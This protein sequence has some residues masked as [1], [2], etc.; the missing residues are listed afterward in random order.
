MIPP[1]VIDELQGSYWV[2]SW[3]FA[4]LVLVV[5]VLLIATF[6]VWLRRRRHLEAHRRR[7]ALVSVGATVLIVIAAGVFANSYSGYI[8]NAPAAI[9][10]VKGLVGSHKVSGATEA[11]GGL[12]VITMP[13]DAAGTVPATQAWVYTP[14]GYDPQ[15]SVHY[16]VLYLFH[17]TPGRSS[18]WFV[19]GNADNAMN[20]LLAHGLVEP[21]I[22]VS[23]DVNGGGKRA[24]TE[25]LDWDD[26]PKVETWMLT[27]VVPFIDASY[28]TIPDRSG[29]AI[30]G[31]SSGGFCALNLALRNLGTWSVVA[32]FEGYGDPGSAGEDAF[33][34]DLERIQANSPSFY[35]P[36]M[37][38]TESLAVYLD[39]G[40]ET[41]DVEDVRAVAQQL[42]DRGQTVL[43]RVNEGES[44]TWSEVQAGLPYALVFASTHLTHPTHPTPQ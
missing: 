11:R 24:D 5:V 19:A 30:G 26:G 33:K 43:F 16:P 18:D 42:V 8:P 3:W 38:F 44:H 22:L 29:R 4:A 25:C 36:T 21:M 23:V 17:G 13:G 20:V 31:M 40:S 35:L 7:V 14:P 34:G 39:V 1:T 28:L 32:S 12:E 10:L 6:V 9:A 15:G 27:D 2:S 37:E 41:R